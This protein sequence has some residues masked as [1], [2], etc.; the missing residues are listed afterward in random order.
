MVSQSKPADVSTKTPDGFKV[1]V[2]KGGKFD[3]KKT[4]LQTN[5]SDKKWLSGLAGAEK[6]ALK[7]YTDSIVASGGIR[8]QSAKPPLEGD[9]AAFVAALNKAEKHEGVVFRGISTNDSKSEG[10][11]AKLL[12]MKPGDT[13]TEKGV[14]STSANPMVAVNFS[15]GGDPASGILFKI[16]TKTATRMKAASFYKS[17]EEVVTKPGAKYRV[18]G[19]HKD[20][21]VDEGNKVK[22]FIE[23]E[24]ID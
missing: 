22:G 23:L 11:A 6:A 1:G 14:A 10:F 12:A 20:A 3:L 15:N 8:K 7:K 9:A 4:S 24:E 2:T 16:R 19:V 13:Y 21:D 18:V 5:D 17:E